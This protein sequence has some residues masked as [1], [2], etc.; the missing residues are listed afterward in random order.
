[1]VIFCIYFLMSVCLD[2][3]NEPR[4]HK[5]T[6]ERLISSWLPMLQMRK[7]RLRWRKH[8]QERL[9]DAGTTAPIPTTLRLFF[10]TSSKY[11][12]KRFFL[13]S[14][15]GTEDVCLSLPG[16][17][18]PGGGISRRQG[19]MR[20]FWK[21]ERCRGRRWPGGGARG[22][23]SAHAPR[24]RGLRAARVRSKGGGGAG[25]DEGPDGGREGT[26]TLTEADRSGMEHLERC[27]WALRGTLVRAAV[28][29]YLPW[30][31]V[32]SMLAGSLLKEVSPLPESYLSNKRN[33]FNV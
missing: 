1:M 18:Y 31:L 4:V 22:L 26:G 5:L 24:G 27:A 9:N 13:R 12:H 29:R 30:A 19:G 10:P 17:C 23:R 7:L 8:L 6:W 15:Q 33:V 14:E 3:H 25:Q 28:R 11:F 20:G 16:A 2:H 32:A 21:Q